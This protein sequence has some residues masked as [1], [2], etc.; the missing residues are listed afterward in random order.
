MIDADW[1]TGG[2][3]RHHLDEGTD[4]LSAPGN[5][6]QYRLTAHGARALAAWDI[7]G[8]VLATDRPLRYCVDWTEQRHHLAGPLGT[9]VTARLFQLEWI[10]RGPVHRSVKLTAPGEAGLARLL[11]TE[12]KV[13]R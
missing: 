2:D 12:S 10:T 7:P 6:T 13:P 11:A 1:V 9:A 4:R 8:P 3:G 5:G